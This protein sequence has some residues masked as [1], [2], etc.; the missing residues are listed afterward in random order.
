LALV[1][2]LDM[3]DR[4]SRQRG[5]VDQEIVSHLMVATE[6]LPK[7]LQDSLETISQQLGI[8]NFPCKKGEAQFIIQSEPITS[9]LKSNTIQVSYGKD[10]VFLDGKISKEKIHPLFEPA[11]S[12]IAACLCMNEVLR[13]CG[14][15]L[16]IEIPKVS[17]LVNL[18]A[19]AFTM[20]GTIDDI[21]F[22]LDGY[23]IEEIDI[24]NVEDGSGQHRVSLRLD[25]DDPLVQKMK[26]SMRITSSHDLSQPNTPSIK[27]NLPNPTESPSGHI[28]LIGAGGLGTWVLKTMVEGLSQ[29]NSGKLDLL[30]FD[31]DS[32]IENHNLNR[33]VIFSEEDIGKP[34]A[35]AASEWLSKNLPS[36]NIKIAYELDDHHLFQYEI[37]D[38][39]EEEID[40]DLVGLFDGIDHD[41][42]IRGH[43]KSTDVILGCLD[44]MHPR[45]LADLAAARMNQPYINA[46]VKGL[47]A[48]YQEFQKTSLVNVHGPAVAK[49]RAVISCQEDGDIPVA[50]IVLTNA[51]VASFQAIAALQRISGSDHASIESVNW[52]LRKNKIICNSSKGEISRVELT[53]V[54]EDALWPKDNKQ[55]V[56]SDKII[57]S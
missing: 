28:T 21:N 17:V 45:V 15:Y 3:Y 10:G 20:N 19:D 25:E 49:D 56:N 43:L 41:N 34:K 36:A 51:L 7:Q 1:E 37:E 18:R 40:P 35:D 39:S 57:N 32:E 23:K 33:Q 2:V 16:P 4:F 5:L 48:Y 11:V 55:E 9:Q 8:K 30:V 44:A 24:H 52:Y 14:A 46:G 38:T 29:C 50:S 42:E 13:R 54:I 47:F 27:F 22:D 26:Q 31:K 6:G 53:S 12:T